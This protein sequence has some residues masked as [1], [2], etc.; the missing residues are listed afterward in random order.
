[1]LEKMD[2]IKRNPGPQAA[3]FKTCKE[4]NN[5]CAP[6]VESSP[7]GNALTLT[8]CCGAVV[9]HSEECTV[10]P[11]AVLADVAEIKSLLGF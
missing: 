5:V 11:C 7:P 9:I 6:S 3:S 4:N 8:A 2:K 10:N 1:M